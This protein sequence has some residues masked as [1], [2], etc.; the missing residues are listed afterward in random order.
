MTQRKPTPQARPAID[1]RMQRGIA[2]HRCCLPALVANVVPAR[3]RRMKNC[4]S[5]ARGQADD[6]DKVDS[7]HRARDR[8]AP[9]VA[10]NVAKASPSATISFL[11]KRRVR[12]A[13][14]QRSKMIRR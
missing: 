3:Q 12:S 9:D 4:A 11:I 7:R 10:Q 5:R 6:D 2:V 13:N 1:G 14:R 8:N